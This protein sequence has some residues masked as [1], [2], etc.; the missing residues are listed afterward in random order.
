MH[1]PSNFSVTVNLSRT[2]Q[3]N[4]TVYDSKRSKQSKKQSTNPEGQT[5]H[6]CSAVKRIQC[7]IPRSN[8]IR[9]DRN[10]VKTS[11]SI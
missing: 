7:N 6:E 4:E 11:T 5:R 8:C 9:N 3:V 1:V 2:L 10:D